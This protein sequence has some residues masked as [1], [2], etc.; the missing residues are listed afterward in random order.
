MSDMSQIAIHPIADIFP[1]LDG[2]EFDALA[3][4]I[5]EHGLREPLWLSK[6]GRLLDGRNR[7]RACQRFGLV[8]ETRTYQGDDIAAFVVSL[9]LRRRHLNE[10][11][12]A[13]VA[14]R[15]ANLPHGGNRRPDQNPNLGFESPPA[16][17]RLGDAAS[18]LNVGRGTVDNARTVS[19][20]GIPELSR[21]V[22]RGEVAVSAAAEVARL[23]VDQQTDIIADGPE[24]V[25]EAAKEIRNH[26]AMG[27]GENEWYTPA[28]YIEAAR[29]F[30][31]EIDLD[32][33]SSEIAN[34]LVRAIEFYSLDDDG[35]TKQW[36]GK[37]WMNPPY[38]QP[39]IAQFIEKL[40][41]EFD[42]AA[43]SEAIALTHNYTDTAWFHRAAASASAIC[44]TRGR[45]AFER[46]DGTKAAPTQGQAFFYFGNRISEFVRRF[47]T[48]G[49][50]VEK[51]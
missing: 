42:N 19:R 2:Q 40:C 9:N 34:K 23:P 16:S 21:A 31:G 41:A 33:A 44:F 24:A 11:Q 35:L 10:S 32:P 15:L 30:L 39:Y 7:L 26:R 50:I 17:I 12:R 22:E 47:H 13:M 28:I 29:D 3:D 14:A 45:I 37:V 4:D 48:F 20:E 27:T 43:V 25:T 1:L 49:L 8:P 38:A 51:A 18:L 5:A 36:R 46:P 6:D